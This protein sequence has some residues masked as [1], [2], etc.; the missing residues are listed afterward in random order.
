MIGRGFGSFGQ[1]WGKWGCVF[2]TNS[3]V[4]VSG[5]DLFAGMADYLF[6]YCVPLLGLWG[7]WYAIKI[8]LRTFKRVSRG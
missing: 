6:F 1:S 8:I 7:I 2:M 5:A 4:M 3:I